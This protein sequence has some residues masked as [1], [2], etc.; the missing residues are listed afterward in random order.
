M[1]NLNGQMW[2]WATLSEVLGG[3]VAIV[4]GAAGGIGK[5]VCDALSARGAAIAAVDADSA[6]VAEQVSTCSSDS[7]TIIG[8]TADITDP[9]QV[10]TMVRKV[11]GELGRIDILVNVAGIL[12][13][14]P[15]LSY[16]LEDWS[17][18]LAVNTTGVFLVSQAVGSTMVSQ[19][20]GSIITV[21]SNAGMVPR[22]HM[23]AYGAS[24]A[25]SILLT[26]CFGLELSPYGIR[27]NIVSP[28]S[29]D[30]SMLRSMWTDEHG[31]SKT[32]SGSLDDFKLGIPLAKLAEPV[33]V[34]GAVVFLASDDS[35]H[36]TMHNICVD[37][38]AT[39]GC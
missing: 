29:T 39:L 31:A 1:A 26:K 27:C 30:T 38:G 18:V 25:A 5:A 19:R 20:S 32:I 16:S 13:T 34:A 6:A 7:R 14:G 21:A 8:I 9:L 33:D 4:T 36:I 12:R 15:I 35:S 23:A 11:K 3:K 17:A 10:N 37:G 22:V 28:G 24:K 2:E